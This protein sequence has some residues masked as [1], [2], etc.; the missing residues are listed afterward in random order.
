[1]QKR[2]FLFCTLFLCQFHIL[3]DQSI[4]KQAL[5]IYLRIASLRNQEVEF[6]A[7]FFNPAFQKFFLAHFPLSL[8]SALLRCDPYSGFRMIHSP[9]IYNKKKQCRHRQHS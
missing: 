8:S 1:M 5:R 3:F 7:F 4:Q 9:F 2:F 6:F